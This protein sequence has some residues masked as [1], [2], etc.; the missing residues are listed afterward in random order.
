MGGDEEGGGSLGRRG[1]STRFHPAGGRHIDPAEGEAEGG[2]RVCRH[3]GPEEHPGFEQNIFFYPP[4]D[5]FKKTRVIPLV[6][7][8]SLLRVVEL[9]FGRFSLEVSSEM[10][11]FS[12]GTKTDERKTK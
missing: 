3:L 10:K 11:F 9:S 4:G 8:I 6:F 12:C 2:G 5:N 7:T 1:S